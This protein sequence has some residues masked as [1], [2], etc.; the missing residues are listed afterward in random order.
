MTETT[1]KSSWG[2]WAILGG[3]AV[4]A[5]GGAYFYYKVIL[6]KALTPMDAAKLVPEKALLAT[7]I[8]TE[9]QTWSKMEQFGTPEAQKILGETW[10]EL[11]PD[12]TQ[13]S[14]I[15]Y[16]QD[17]KPWLGNIM[18]AVLPSDV[19]TNQQEN[20]LM[21]VGIKNKAKALQF[22]LKMRQTLKEL[23][24]T[25]YKGFPI[26]RGKTSEDES[27]SF[28]LINDYLVVS[29]EEAVINASI[30]TVKGEASLATKGED[31]EIF[32][33]K[34]GLKNPIAQMY[35]PNYSSFV[36]QSLKAVEN[37]END[38]SLPEIPEVMPEEIIKEL[39]KIESV[40][41][42]LGIEDE[43]LHF[44]AIT[45]VSDEVK[46]D[47]LQT[48][49]GKL[50]DQFPKET[51]LLIAGQGISQSWNYLLQD[52]EKNPEL[53]SV[54]TEARKVVKEELNLDL[55]QDIFG[56]MDGEFA[57]G[58]INSNQGA[59]STIGMGGALIIETSDRPKG[60][61]TIKTLME[62]LEPQFS[63]FILPSETKIDGIDAKTWKTPFQQEVFGYG[64]KDKGFFLLTLGT[65]FDNFINLTKQE[66]LGK[67][68]HFQEITKA[69][70]QD[71]LGYFYFDLRQAKNT[72]QTIAQMSGYPVTPESQA[73]LDSVKGLAMTSTLPENSI[74]AFEMILSLE[75]NQK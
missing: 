25:D 1:K 37:I 30:D 7:Y 4:I 16:D 47:Y 43:G 56:W 10:A 33:Q 69:L 40:V 48:N 55:D 22:S 21:V 35:I 41:V 54:L 44:K 38:E 8:S 9:P 23:E 58:M 66:S 36:Q 49:Q 62:L 46:F 68:A 11:L 19:A 17:I 57:F 51:F 12:V 2:L 14:N 13:E 59:L 73:F 45:Q 75:K 24:E 39:D 65:P 63:G 53:N 28:A 31:L 42:G 15:S 67:S 29:S 20:V 70:P 72:F 5:A 61:N 6:G 50:L 18:V 27:V 60:E 32:S 26:S 74:I 34:L 71:N 52:I 64:W 3:V